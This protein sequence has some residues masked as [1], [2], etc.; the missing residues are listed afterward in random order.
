M[1]KEQ[2]LRF[3][4]VTVVSIAIRVP[5]YNCRFTDTGRGHSL[6][7]NGV[8]MAA[9]PWVLHLTWKGR[10]LFRLGVPL[11]V[12]HRQGALATARAVLSWDWGGYWLCTTPVCGPQDQGRQERAQ[13]SCTGG[14]HGVPYMQVNFAFFTAHSVIGPNNRGMKWHLSAPHVFFRH[15]SGA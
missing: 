3:K 1:I 8:D 11:G 6:A 7:G 5:L 9:I 2:I 15:P 13:R 10:S 12:A 14:E 4:T